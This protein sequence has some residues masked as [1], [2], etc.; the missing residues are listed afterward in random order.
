MISPGWLRAVDWPNRQI[1]VD[2]TAIRSIQP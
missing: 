1:E 2:L